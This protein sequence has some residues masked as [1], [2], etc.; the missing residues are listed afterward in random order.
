M[1]KRFSGGVV[2]RIPILNSSFR[3]SLWHHRFKCFRNQNNSQREDPSRSA[4][5]SRTPLDEVVSEEATESPRRLVILEKA[6]FIYNGRFVAHP[7]V[8]LKRPPSREW[9]FRTARQG[10]VAFC[11]TSSDTPPNRASGPSGRTST[12]RDTSYWQP[13]ESSA[14]A[15]SSGAIPPRSLSE[16]KIPPRGINNLQAFPGG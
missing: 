10:G 13:S 1:S 15:D 4:T 7:E 9:T 16:R 12:G 2:S 8:G 3:P 6:K 14:S 11:S 5:A